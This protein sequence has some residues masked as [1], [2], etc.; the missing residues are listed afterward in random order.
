MLRFAK[1]A[2]PKQTY[3]PSEIEPKWQRFWAEHRVFRAPN[4]GDPDFDPS[5]PKFYA[6]DM[7]PYPSGAGLHVG[8]PEG[9]TATDIVSRMKRMTGHNVL[10][11]M[12]WDAFGLPAEQ[13]AIQ[14]GRHPAETTNENIATFRRQLQSLG[15]SYD[16]DREVATCDPGYFRWT[17][18]I[19]ARLYEQGLAYQSNAPVWWCEALGTV[20]S[21]DEV[22]N[23]RS[24]R[25]D[26]PCERRPLRQWMLK[27]TAHAERLLRDLDEL[28][29]TDSLKAQQRE[30]IGR[31]EGA[32]IEFDVDG[33]AGQR[34]RVFT[35]RP[36]TLFGASFM[37]LAP[38]HAL[39][40]KITASA[41][42]A[43]VRAYARQAASKSELERTELAKD[44]TGV[45]L[46]AFA[47]NPLFRPDDPRARLPIW[48]ADYVLASYGTGAIMAVPAGDERDFEFATKFGIPVPPIFAP[49]TGDAE[50]D[51][52]VREGRACCT[53][54]APYANSNNDDGLDL[55]GLEQVDAVRATIAWLAA[56]GRGEAKVQYR[57][58][59]WLFSRQRYW[60]EPFPV[61]FRGD[62]SVELVPDAELPV[63]LPDMAD[64]APRGTPESPLARATEWVATVDSA[65]R[66]A[67]R[68]INTMP[69]AAGSSWY[70]LRFCDPHNEREFCSRAASDY[71][72]PVDLYVGGTEHAVGH[73]LYARFWTKVLHDLGL[74]GVKE[75]FAK[76]YNQGMILSFAYEDERGATVPLADVEERGDGSYVQKDSG[77]PLR[78]TVTKMSK[79]YGNVVNPD[80]V[81]REY[82]AD[83]LRLYEMYMGPLADPKPWNPKDVP[84]VHR[85]LGRVWRLC[86]P[87]EPDAGAV[88]GWLRADRA[89]DDALERALARCIDKVTHDIERLA[90]NTAIAAMMIFVNEATRQT[91]RLSRDQL[92]RF[93]QLLSP[94]A[95]HIAEELWSRL[96]GSGLLAHSTWPS[97]DSELLRED[98]V[99]L[100]VQVLGKVRGRV[101]V[102]ADAAP[103]DV[104]Q[105]AREAVQAHLAGRTIEK[106]IVVPGKIVNFVVA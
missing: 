75:P 76:L 67:T 69:G 29:W 61:R 1:M 19:F 84:G 32:E 85:F 78:Q 34:I 10:H 68:E 43:A 17:Q 79:R 31:S 50:A 45:F 73:L 52:R 92:L 103:D 74:V 80:D 87:E 94:F 105:A 21:N 55:A 49:D 20:L 57:M 11:P 53:V 37:V 12:G 15:F 56:R 63:E 83:T 101:R 33:H 3:R 91:D 72:M 97:V 93:V 40:E 81:V 54:E 26:H 99:E 51:R 18:W 70:F 88:H 2:E 22:V 48:I 8:H 6:L 59:D 90:F 64:F 47:L 82:G 44:K 9:Y 100:A 66:L 16:W 58:R 24:E 27:I 86:V 104:L 39:V 35:T 95:P 71:W 102:A 65:G 5:K 98:T 41:Q 62:G 28:D 89:P 36:D 7:F 42:R 46:G 25:G 77:A 106:E 14:T 38:E 60:G 96:G 4:P 23:G 13:Y 30:W